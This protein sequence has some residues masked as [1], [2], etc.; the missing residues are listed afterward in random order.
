MKTLL[1]QGPLH[2]CRRHQMPV[3]HRLSPLRSKARQAPHCVKEQCGTHVTATVTEATPTEVALRL[4]KGPRVSKKELI[5]VIF[6]PAA[7]PSVADPALK[8]RRSSTALRLHHETLNREQLVT[9][10]LAAIISLLAD[11]SLLSCAR[12]NALPL[13]LVA[14]LPPSSLAVPRHPLSLLRPPPS[15]VD[16]LPPVIAITI[17]MKPTCKR[18]NQAGPSSRAGVW[19]RLHALGDM[20]TSDIPHRPPAPLSVSP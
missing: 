1:H 6:P 5:D 15:A 19:P 14:C 18:K 16:R 17:I 4:L 9:L 3:Q 20:P 13:C 12:A 2:R 8:A 11:T 7:A 10:S